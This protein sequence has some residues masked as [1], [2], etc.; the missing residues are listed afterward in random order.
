MQE[1]QRRWPAA[2][3]PT[4]LLWVDFL[5]IRRQ[6]LKQR[7][8]RWPFLWATNSI[9]LYVG[10]VRF[11]RRESQVYGRSKMLVMLL[12]HSYKTTIQSVTISVTM[13]NTMTLILIQE[14]KYMLQLSKSGRHWPKTYKYPSCQWK[15]PIR[16][17]S[18]LVALHVEGPECN[19]CHL[20]VLK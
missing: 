14:K 3:L 4:S 8:T 16:Q 12:S 10:K 1:D 7:Y 11:Q 13:H 18:S 17:R 20:N 5:Q 9:T 6:Q 19:L 2:F 15:T